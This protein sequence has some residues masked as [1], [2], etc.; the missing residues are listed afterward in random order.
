MLC[1]SLHT[2]KHAHRP[3]SMFDVWLLLALTSGNGSTP[4]NGSSGT[5]PANVV[6]AGDLARRRAV[7][8]ASRALGFACLV[9]E[10]SRDAAVVVE[11]EARQHGHVG[12]VVRV[13][14]DERGR[15][16]ADRL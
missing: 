13:V 6:V 10:D 1:L 16:A 9:E 14:R 4:A 11:R 3:T 15:V 8:L 7:E 5:S 2:T 12:L